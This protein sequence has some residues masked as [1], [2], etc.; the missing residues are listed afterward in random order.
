MATNETACGSFNAADYIPF[1]LKDE[2]IEINCPIKVDGEV[3]EI[4]LSRL[5]DEEKKQFQSLLKKIQKS[6]VWKPEN[7]EDYY[8]ITFGTICRTRWETIQGDIDA[9][10]IGN[11]FPTKEAAMFALEKLKVI[12]EIKRYIEEYDPI[13]IDWNDKKQHKHYLIYNI[14]LDRI[15]P[16]DCMVMKQFGTI[17]F[18]T[19]LDWYKM[20]TTIGINRIKKYIFGVE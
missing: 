1:K 6:K 19:K 3:L 14:T 4:D 9:Y 20:I 2:S 5:D 13:K 7:G 12:A 16:K 15:E 10:A 18:S 17:Y 8:Y 11:C